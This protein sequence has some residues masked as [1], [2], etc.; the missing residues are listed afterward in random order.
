MHPYGG[1]PSASL[2][3][4]RSGSNLVGAG[5]GAG[6][7]LRAGRREDGFLGPGTA[8]SARMASGAGAGAGS[9]PGTPT[10]SIQGMSIKDEPLPHHHPG[11]S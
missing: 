5:A 7:G 6:L 10:F 8:S 11:S 2:G 1:A 9:G 4:P 3:R